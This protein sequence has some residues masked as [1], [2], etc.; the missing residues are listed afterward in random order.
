[1]LSLFRPINSR[2]QSSQSQHRVRQTRRQKPNALSFRGTAPFRTQ[3]ELLEDRR[4]LTI[5]FLVGPDINITKS[6]ANEA[7]TTIAINPANT[8]NLFAIDTNTY[9]GRY[10]TDGGQTWLL[11]NMAGFTSA[12]AHDAQA[13]WDSFGNLFVTRM[14]T[15]KQVEVGISSNGGAS[16]SSVQII[17]GSAGNT[18]QPTLAVG[19]SGVAGTPGAVWVSYEQSAV[20]KASGAAVNGLGLVGAFIAPETAPGSTN[21]DFGSMSIGPAGQVLVNYQDGLSGGAAGGEGPGT[22]SSNLDPDG[23]G[24]TGFNGAITAHST[25]VGGTAAIPPQPGPFNVGGRTIDAEAN[26]AYD[27]TGGLHNGRSYMVYTDRSSV[28]PAA[29]NNT[30]IFVIYSDN[31]GT[32]WSAPVR[33]ND[34][35]SSGTTGATQYLPAIA[36]D[37]TTGDVA[38]SWYDTRNSGTGTTRD[39]YASVS[40]DGGNTWLPNVRLSAALSNPLAAAV[41]TFNSG[42]L[43]LMSYANGVF[44]RSWSDNSNS[45]GDNPAGVGNTYD[46]YTARVA[47]GTPPT[48]TTPPITQTSVEGSATTFTLGSFSD[49]DGGP[50]S[51]DVSWGDGQPDT[52]FSESTAGSLGTGIHTYG[53]EGNFTATVTVTDRLGFSGSATFHVAVSDPLVVPSA[54]AINAVEGADTGSVLVAKFIDPGGPEA[55]GDYSADIDWGDGTG[56][57]VGAGAI[58][59]NG[60]TFEVRGS[61]TYVEESAADHAGSNPYQVTVT[62]H[63]EATTPQSVVSTA[64]VSDPP[65][66]PFGGFAFIATEGV[67][68]AV[69]TVATFLDPGGSEPLS[70]YSALIDWG[71]GTAPSAGTISFASGTYTVQGSHTYAVGLGLPDDF[72]NTFCDGTPPSFHKPIT[73][74]ISHE[75]AP[76]AQAV[77]DATISIAPGTAHLAG[78][79]LIVV[80]TTADD[81]VEITPVGNTGAVKVA[82]NSHQLGS[83]TLGAGGRII[84]AGLAGNDD[85]QVAGGV[86]LP[87]VLYGGPGSDRLKGGDGP[88]I[89]VGCSG[90]DELIG[91]LSNDL[92]IGG[93][94][95]D[96]LNGGQGDD[97]LVSA[98]IVNPITLAEDTKFSHLVAALNGGPIMAD[99][100]GDVDVLTGA[101]GTDTFFYH[102]LGNL[103]LDIVTDK[104]EIAFNV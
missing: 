11:S 18:D 37:Q 44:Y 1:M 16:F 77:S 63:H 6:A 9:Q 88:N 47:V 61:H 31:D 78:G 54:V 102:Y 69:Q 8:N 86:R 101:A 68:S 27:D 95:A 90:D 25:N 82:L 46:I 73:V 64:T 66:T 57:Q 75:A 81:H 2:T 22:I 52:T 60:T 29:N 38:V 50:W 4:L 92:L 104:A 36:L 39:T 14:G 49:P 40:L 72:G 80:A 56:T 67:P 48:V 7:E 100:D 99:D 20:I 3:L 5:G 24:P 41:G 85:I 76:T 96:R 59:L 33:V 83:F 21:G 26:L 79:S 53:E 13:V 62:V 32:S 10:S 42:D 65:V 19:P 93:D 45:T 89:L 28:P 97:I 35:P 70:D 17:P 87:T 84:V 23:L 15:G 103:P 34:D 74:T 98:N 91:G 30:D 71:D 94:G 55:V 58:T 43:D 12:P 51:V